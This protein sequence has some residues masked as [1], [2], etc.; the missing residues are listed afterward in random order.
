MRAEG[1][2][3]QFVII[4]AAVVDSYQRSGTASAGLFIERAIDKSP[5]R[6]ESHQ[7][8]LALQVGNLFVQLVAGRRGNAGSKTSSSGFPTRW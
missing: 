2:E 4:Q 7:R 6:F 1:W 3:G 8:G 5:C